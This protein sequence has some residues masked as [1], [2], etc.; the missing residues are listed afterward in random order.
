[1]KDGKGLILEIMMEGKGFL[2]VKY[3]AEERFPSSW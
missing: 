2:L 1:M 3:E